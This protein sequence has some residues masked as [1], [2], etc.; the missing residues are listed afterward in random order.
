MSSCCSCRASGGTVVQLC[1]GLGQQGCKN[2]RREQLVAALPAQLD[3]QGWGVQQVGQG[4]GA[5]EWVKQQGCQ[6]VRGAS[7]SS[8]V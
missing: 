3:A 7:S 4:E 1:Q 6:G 2:T 5:G 8:N